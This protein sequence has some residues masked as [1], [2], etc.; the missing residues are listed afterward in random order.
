MPPQ[1]SQQRQALFHGHAG[2]VGGMRDID[3]QRLAAGFGVRAYHGM[4]RDQN[5]IAG[6]GLFGA[7]L[8]RA[9]GLGLVR[10]G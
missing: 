1:Q 8:S 10:P 4:F 2:E 9:A 7:V 5:V 6:A 3:I